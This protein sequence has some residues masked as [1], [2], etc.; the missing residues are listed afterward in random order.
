[1]TRLPG[2]VELF[3]L[4][5]NPAIDLLLGLA[6][7]KGGPQHLVLLG[8]EGA[9]GLLEGGLELLLLGLQPPPLLVQLVNRS[10]AVSKLVKKILDLVSQVLK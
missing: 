1:M 2:V 6:K 4:L 7:L 3:L 9:L 5:R 8:L 10:T